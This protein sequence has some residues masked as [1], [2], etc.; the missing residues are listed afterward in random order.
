MLL[1]RGV[2]DVARW[3]RLSCGAARGSE[4]RRVVR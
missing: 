4:D 1:R 3:S 2:E